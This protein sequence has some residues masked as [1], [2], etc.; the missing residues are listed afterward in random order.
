MI[1]EGEL[2]GR[3]SPWRELYDPNRLKPMVS[4]NSF[5]K[6]NA[7]VARRLVGDRLTKR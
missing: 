2:Q 3:E 1:L 4:A 6:E 5:I 7:N